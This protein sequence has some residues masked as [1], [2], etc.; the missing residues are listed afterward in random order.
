MVSR[1]TFLGGWLLAACAGLGAW[2]PPAHAAAPL[3]IWPVDPMIA[4]GQRAVALW[5]ENRGEE[6]VSVQVRV[7][8]WTQDQGDDQ[9]DAQKDVIPSPPIADIAPGAR[10]LVRL[11]ALVPASPLSEDAYR[12][13]VDELPRPAGAAQSAGGPAPAPALGVQLQVRY[14]I[15]LFVYGAGAAG[16][17]MSATALAALNG[18][19]AQ[20]LE[21][22][23]SWR[24]A[25]DGDTHRLVLRNAGRAHAR[26]T[27]VSWQAADAARETAI[28]PG[29]LGYVLPGSERQWEL[30][31]PPAG[32]LLLKASVN[33]R[34]ALVPR[35]AP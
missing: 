19:A 22:N 32:P 14:A 8:G 20:P 31:A 17:R 3:M 1:A 15:P 2:A 26:L 16:P 34:P 18:E 5:I 33:G 6:P 11:M 23:L 13:I 9:F 35:A 21:A 7:M 10:Q 28:N 4:G 27:A 29:L 30:P 12:V 25:S 24:I